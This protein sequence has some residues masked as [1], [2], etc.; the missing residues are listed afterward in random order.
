MGP[1]PTLVASP[2]SKAPGAGTGSPG[3][4]EQTT[5]KCHKVGTISTFQ[6]DDE[7]GSFGSA[8]SISLNGKR[9][10]NSYFFISFLEDQFPPNQIRQNPPSV[11]D[12][13]SQTSLLSDAK[14]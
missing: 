3:P 14:S 9:L 6:A 11:F 13:S 7:G 10:G 4:L 5:G 8:F 1:E 12:L 2:S